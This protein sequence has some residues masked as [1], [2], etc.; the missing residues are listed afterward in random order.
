MK[1][2]TILYYAMMGY[3]FISTISEE[4][5]NT[6]VEAPLAMID[7]V[8]ICVSIYIVVGISMCG[9]GFG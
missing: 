3:D 2:S 8:V 5:N 4:A 6:K 7:T 9:M 1:G